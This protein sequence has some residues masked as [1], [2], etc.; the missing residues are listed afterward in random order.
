VP[1]EAGL[2]VPPDDARAFAAAL[3]E[4]LADTTLR[5]RLA[6]GS[7]RAGRSLPTWSHTASIAG[8]ILDRIASN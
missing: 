6:E 1:E 7:A 4:V 2:L 5:R 3:R 8:E